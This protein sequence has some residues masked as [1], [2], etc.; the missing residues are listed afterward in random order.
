M[1]VILLERRHLQIRREGSSLSS[2][3]DFILG[4]GVDPRVELVFADLLFERLI[5]AWLEDIWYCASLE[6][7][8]DLT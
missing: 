8:L 1:L 3:E 2:S 6:V 7:R 4:C 5:L